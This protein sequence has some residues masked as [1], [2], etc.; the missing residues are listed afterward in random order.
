MNVSVIPHV[1]PAQAGIQSRIETPWPPA[2]SLVEGRLCA[3]ETWS[4][5][6]LVETPS[7]TLRL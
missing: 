3:G 5:L 2:P 4:E 6:I 7:K 1:I